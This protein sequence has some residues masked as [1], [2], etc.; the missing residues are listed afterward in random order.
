MGFSPKKITVCR[1]DFNKNAKKDCKDRKK[2][3]R[4]CTIQIMKEE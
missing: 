1:V 2:N 3:V 4:K